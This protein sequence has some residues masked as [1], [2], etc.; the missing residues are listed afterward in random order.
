MREICC[1]STT[2]TEH[3]IISTWLTVEF[4]AG[5]L[6]PRPSLC[7]SV[8]QPRKHTLVF[9]LHIADKG[10]REQDSLFIFRCPSYEQELISVSSSQPSHPSRSAPLP[11]RNVFRC[12]FSIRI[13][14]GFQPGIPFRSRFTVELLLLQRENM[15]RQ[16][17]L[18][19]QTVSWAAP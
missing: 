11:R 9:L 5:Q 12:F 13:C 14:F 19:G 3:F 2:L 10:Q 6:G 7:R 15:I 4:A 17:F 16:D 18:D 8:G 1:S